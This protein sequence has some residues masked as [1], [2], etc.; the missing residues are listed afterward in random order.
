[1]ARD[2]TVRHAPDAGAS[3]TARLPRLRSEDPQTR[4]EELERQVDA[5]Q[6]TCQAMWE[7]LA[8]G[9][10]LAP[11]ALAK[12]AEEI[13]LRDGL[14]DGRL[15]PAPVDCPGCGKRVGAHRANCYYC[16]SPLSKAAP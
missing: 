11:H 12:R 16:G 6:L 3:R 1:M 8:P 5:L 9:A 4:I 14:L 2:E 13:D 7:L 10:G 15:A